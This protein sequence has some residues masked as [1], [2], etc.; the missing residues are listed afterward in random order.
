MKKIL[1]IIALSSVIT[2]SAFA[3]STSTTNQGSA[4]SQNNHEM[5]SSN[6]QSTNNS[7]GTASRNDNLT[8][9]YDNIGNPTNINGNSGAT[10]MSDND[11]TMNH[12]T[13][14]HSHMKS[15]KTNNPSS[16]KPATTDDN[17]IKS[18]MK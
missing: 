16:V 1:T 6:S 13:M 11:T 2:T 17:G 8:K 5:N 10:G 12:T 4:Y 3:Q 15:K 14:N 9:Q 7:N 18:D